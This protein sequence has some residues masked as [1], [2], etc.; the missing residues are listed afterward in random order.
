MK[1]PLTEKEDFLILACDGLWDTI[2]YIEAARTVY[3][4]VIADPG[5]FF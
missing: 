5:N 4:A 1:I 3:E 2:S